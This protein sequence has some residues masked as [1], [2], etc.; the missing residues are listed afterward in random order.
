M[1]DLE[2]LFNEIRDAYVTHFKSAITKLSGDSTDLQIEPIRR[3]ED[4]NV[5][6]EGLLDLP[7][8]ADFVTRNRD[9]DEEPIDIEIVSDD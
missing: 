8:R 9:G 7:S 1:P 6:Y 4:G 5:R 3:D 2:T